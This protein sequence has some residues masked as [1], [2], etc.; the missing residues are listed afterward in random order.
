[1]RTIYKYPIEIT[2][3]QKIEMPIGEVLHA[4]LDPSGTPCI[5]AAVDTEC[6]RISQEILIYG[7]GNTMPVYPSGRR[8]VGTF[9]QGQFVWHVF[10]GRASAIT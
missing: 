9:V 7:T 5:W 10:A 8:H 2:D 4:G 6:D 1:M 3:L